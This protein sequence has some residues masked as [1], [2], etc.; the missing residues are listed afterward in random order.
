MNGSFFHCSRCERCDELGND[1]LHA[2]LLGRPTRDAFAPGRPMP[3][4][5]AEPHTSACTRAYSPPN[6]NGNAA[7]TKLGPIGA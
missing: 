5:S 2:A 1:D 6:R 3:R 7:W 4:T